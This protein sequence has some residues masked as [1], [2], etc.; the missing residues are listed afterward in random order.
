M[1]DVDTPGD[2]S[3]PR[4]GASHREPSG[5]THINQTPGSLN[6][7]GPVVE[8]PPARASLS[9]GASMVS[10]PGYN[11]TTELLDHPEATTETETTVTR[12]RHES[13]AY[14]QG[15]ISPRR[16]HGHP[17]SLRLPSALGR[18]PSEASKSTNLSP[19]PAT[20]VKSKDAVPSSTPSSASP[21]KPNAKPPANQKPKGGFRAFFV[22]SRVSFQRPFY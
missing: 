13:S 11:S 5:P 16:R 18:K 19:I 10:L 9:A 7:D 20:P 14:V 4:N 17:T 15:I 2:G 3:H 12:E 6:R 8:R 1:G 21:Q 22:S